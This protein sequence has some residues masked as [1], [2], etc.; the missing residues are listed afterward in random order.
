M[1]THVRVGVYLAKHMSMVVLSYESFHLSVY[2]S[3]RT[4]ME[5]AGRPLGQHGTH[6]N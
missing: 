2:V 3:S 6:C 4:K 1:E 5:V